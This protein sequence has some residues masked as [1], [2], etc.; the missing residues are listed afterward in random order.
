MAS[1]IGLTALHALIFFARNLVKAFL[2]V[3]FNQDFY[4]VT[5]IWF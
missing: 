1:V 3:V 4:G 5:S 2:G